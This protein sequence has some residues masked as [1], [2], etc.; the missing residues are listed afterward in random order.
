MF[1]AIQLQ[2][3]MKTVPSTEFQK[4]RLTWRA[5]LSLA[6]VLA[7]VVIGSWIV[8]QERKLARQ[9]AYEIIQKAASRA[10]KR[11]DHN[12]RW[13]HSVNRVLSASV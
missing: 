8:Y 3:R 6:P 2:N 10:I 11:V 12:L 7:L 4:P 9:E 5:W 13:A 1:D